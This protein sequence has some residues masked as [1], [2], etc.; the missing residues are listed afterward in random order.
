[1]RAD[2]HG[3]DGAVEQLGDLLMVEVLEAREDE[4][5][6]MFV[7]NASEGAAHEIDRRT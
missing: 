5:F 7:G 1:M 4:D 6:A 2:L 3:A